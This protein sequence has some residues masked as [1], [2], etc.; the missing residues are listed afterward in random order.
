[1]SDEIPRRCQ[2]E[3][4]VPAEVAIMAA[5]YAVEDMGADV[6]LTNAVALLQ[7]AKEQVADFI[8]GII[9]TQ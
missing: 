2:V 8:D 3:L 5:M 4:M 9:P 7:Q 6:R 1:M